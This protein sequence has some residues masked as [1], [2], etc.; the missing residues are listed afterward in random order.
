[1]KYVYSDLHQLHDPQVEIED[2]ALNEPSERPARLIEIDRALIAHGGFTKVEPNSHGIYPIKRTHEPALVDFLA[3]AW[4]RFQDEVRPSR[5]V[6]PDVFAMARLRDG[7]TEGLAP[8]RVEA[9][10]GWYCFETTTPLVAETF[11]AARS[12]VDV[13]L[14]ATDLVLDELLTAGKA[15]AVYAACRPPGHH[16]ARNIYGGYCFF[17][18]VAIAADHAIARLNESWPEDLSQ[19][20]RPRVSVLDVDYHHGNGTQQIFYDRADVQFISLHADPARAYPF[21]L[22]FAEE[23]GT[24]DGVGANLNI[25]L[26]VQIDDAQFDAAL[27]EAMSH[28]EKFKPDLLFVSLGLDISATDPLGDFAVTPD[29][30]KKIG[31]RIESA[32]LP[33]VIVQEGGYDVSRLG[34]YLTS[35]LQAFVDAEPRRSSEIFARHQTRP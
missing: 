12:A 34:S 24:G 18:N 20:E 33:T 32:G 21:H 25:P 26:G 11:T 6:V 13:A 7:M 17:N 22:G 27:A 3:E 10:L 30:F 14:T 23:R 2:S 31:R 8:T 19:N 28:I 29:G 1:M 9:Q 5:E 16:A 15:I 4:Q 35:F